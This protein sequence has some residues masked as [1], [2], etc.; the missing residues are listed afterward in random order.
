MIK[1]VLTASLL[2]T[3]AI[4]S[5][6]I[7]ASAAD[8]AQPYGRGY[9]QPIPVELFPFNWTGPYA[10]IEVGKGSQHIDVDNRDPF[11]S[12]RLVGGVVGIN[13][14]IGNLLAGIEVDVDKASMHGINNFYYADN[15]GD[16]FH[17]KT[18]TNVAAIASINAK[19][20]IVTGAKNE[21]AF[22]GI[23]GITGE[24]G[25]TTVLN[26]GSYGN[27]T[28]EA[29]KNSRR[30]TDWGLDAG[31]GAAVRVSQNVTLAAEYTHTWFNNPKTVGTPYSKY[32]NVLDIAPHGADTVKAKVTLSF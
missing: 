26:T 25:D 16:H 31:L 15:Q 6:A 8:V 5:L 11:T 20:G 3:T 29:D 10:G 14:Q 22:Y 18:T 17:V 28:W 9:Q 21:F 1:R 19:L 7:S 4:V 23:G 32:G 27:A 2:A 24:Y 30:F 12:G 13:Q